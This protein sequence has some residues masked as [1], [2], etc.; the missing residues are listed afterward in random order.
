MIY[1]ALLFGS[2]CKS[3]ACNSCEPEISGA[4]LRCKVPDPHPREN[5]G[6]DCTGKWVRQDRAG[7]I[8]FCNSTCYFLKQGRYIT[9]CPFSYVSSLDYRGA[10][11]C[12]LNLFTWSLCCNCVNTFVCCFF[13]QGHVLF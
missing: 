10:R 3:T 8:C 6:S 4:N 1:H 9:R 5:A 2:R 11:C 13:S 12:F 7:I